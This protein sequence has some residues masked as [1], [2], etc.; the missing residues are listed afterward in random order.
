ML[1]S[2]IG[3]SKLSLVPQ[4]CLQPPVSAISPYQKASPH[5]SPVTL[6]YLNPFFHQSEHHPTF[7]P[8]LHQPVKAWSSGCGRPGKRSFPYRPQG[9]VALGILQPWLK[10]SVWKRNYSGLPVSLL[11]WRKKKKN[12]PW[13]LLPF[14]LCKFIILTLRRSKK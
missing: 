13:P 10:Q 4:I 12:S 2:L 14:W 9:H 5:S 6:R 7:N 1:L 3:D 8:Y 11:L